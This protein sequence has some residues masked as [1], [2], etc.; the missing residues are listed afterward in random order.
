MAQESDNLFYYRYINIII[1]YQNFKFHCA[2]DT[3]A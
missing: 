3:I 2:D 1:Y